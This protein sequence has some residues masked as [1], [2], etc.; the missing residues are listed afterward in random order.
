MSLLQDSIVI[1]IALFVFVI[2]AVTLGLIFQGFNDAIQISNVDQQAKDSIGDI[3][4]GW[5]KVMDWIFAALLFG[6]PL[7]SMGLAYF[8]RVPLTFFYVVIA[9]MVLMLF[10]GW[11]FQAGWED[12]QANGGVFSAYAAS[13]MPITNF[14]MLNFGIYALVA[15]ALIGWGT[16]VK[17]QEGTGFG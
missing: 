4:N 8:N 2:A 10:V 12:L 14:V 16:Y 3:D 1:I 17:S 6:L 9:V 5:G 13:Q 11:A 15:V 7:T